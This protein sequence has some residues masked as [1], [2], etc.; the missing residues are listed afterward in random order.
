MEGNWEVV[1]LCPR[2][3]GILTYAGLYVYKCQSCQS[4]IREKDLPKSRKVQKKRR[5]YTPVWK[6]IMQ[7]DLNEIHDAAQGF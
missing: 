2:C 7:V 6:R 4:F 3:G 5:K 1:K